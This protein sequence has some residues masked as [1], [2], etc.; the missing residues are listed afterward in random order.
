MAKLAGGGVGL[1]I[2][3]HT[4]VSPE[5]QASYRQ[6]GVYGDELI[7]GLEDMANA[8]HQNGGKIVM[9]LAHAGINADALIVAELRQEHQK[10]ALA[11][12]DFDNLLSMKVVFIDDAFRES[13]MEGIED[14]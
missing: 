11:A 14:T 9:Q 12:T 10:L 5:G 2:S 8:V 13:F 1:I 3:S 6:L 4:Y 7:P